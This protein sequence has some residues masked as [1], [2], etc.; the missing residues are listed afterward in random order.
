M[1][2]LLDSKSYDRRVRP[3]NSSGPVYVTVNMF[4][5]SVSKL[6]E[7]NNVSKHTDFIFNYFIALACDALSEFFFLIGS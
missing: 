4:L 6:D 7:I 2:K 5:R 3:V 1:T